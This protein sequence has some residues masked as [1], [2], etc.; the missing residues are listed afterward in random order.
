MNNQQPNWQ[1]TPPSGNNKGLKGIIIACICVLAILL[2]VLISLLFQNQ[3][4][5]VF[6]Q[7]AG[8][9]P[10]TETTDKTATKPPNN[11]SN[12]G[13]P[14]YEQKLSQTIYHDFNGSPI[15]FENRTYYDS[16]L[17]CSTTLYT[18]NQIGRSADVYYSPQYTFLY[19][20]NEKGQQINRVYGA[21]GSTPSYDNSGYTIELFSEYD[22]NRTETIISPLSDN[23]N[24]EQFGVDPSKTQEI[25]GEY[26]TIPANTSENWATTYLNKVLPNIDTTDMTV[27]SLLHI[28]DNGIPEV[29][30]D[31]GYSYAG[32]EIFTARN[33]E[34]ANAKLSSLRWVKQ[35]GK[36]LDA[37]GRMDVYLD[38][39]YEIKDGS[40]ICT[41]KGNYGAKDNSRVEIDANGE[42]IYSYYWND[43]EVSKEVY[44]KN[45]KAVFPDANLPRNLPN[46]FTLD[47]LT[48]LLEHVANAD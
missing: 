35:T 28:D 13:A 29:W 21:L 36:F 3:Y 43:T 48:T 14:D 4:P 22:E 44:T 26:T 25:Y 5:K 8:K 1:S 41:D 33:S 46:I 20:Y 42:P 2:I 11:N 9:T 34:V 16:G 12:S 15:Y 37:G 32:E 45:L 24:Q 38:N 7:L 6:Y 39:V 31:H 27:C 23:I 18:V 30:F 10:V 17:L 19:L 40:F 47:Q